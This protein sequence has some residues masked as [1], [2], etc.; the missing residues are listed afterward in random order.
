MK[1]ICLD[2]DGTYTELPELMNMIIDYGSKHNIQVILATMRYPEEIDD[3]L[4]ELQKK[5]DV[6]FTCRNAKQN[7]LLLQGINPDIWVDDSPKWIVF[8]AK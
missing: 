8:D 1:T 4:K 3:G 2:Y 6:Y 7:Y 5:I